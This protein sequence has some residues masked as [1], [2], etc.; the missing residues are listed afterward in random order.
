MESSLRFQDIWRDWHDDL[1]H[2]ARHDAPKLFTILI[3]AFILIR[4]LGVITR[5]MVE[6]S[7][8]AAPRASVRAQQISTIVGV[9][10]S[11]G[12]FVVVLVSALQILPIFGLNIAP[13]LASA[14]IAGLAIGFGAGFPRC[15]R[16]DAFSSSTTRPARRSRAPCSRR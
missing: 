14:G 6:L 9:I 8:R 7:K 1:V 3:L 2:F 10:R 16:R 15:S 13:L 4:L 11:A 12:I 5:K